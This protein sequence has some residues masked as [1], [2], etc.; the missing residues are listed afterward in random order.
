MDSGDDRG[1][2]PLREV[3]PVVP[4][5]AVPPPDPPERRVALVQLRGS[6]VVLA[7]N[8]PPL[9]ALAAHLARR[10]AIEADPP[11]AGAVT[12]EVD[13]DGARVVVE[14][15]PRF[16][17]TLVPAAWKREAEEPIVRLRRI[18]GTFADP[19]VIEAWVRRA[20]DGC[21]NRPESEEALRRSLAAIITAAA[22]CPAVCFTAASA[23]EAMRRWKWWPSAAEVFAFC[24]E[25][26]KPYRNQLRGLEAVAAAPV[27]TGPGRE[28]P[29][30]PDPR[31]SRT[32]EEVEAVRAKAAAVLAE[33]RAREAEE[34]ER[35]PAAAATRPVSVEHRIAHLEIAIREA[36]GPG[37]KPALDWRLE[38]LR[39]AVGLDA[40]ETR[41][42]VVS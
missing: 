24:E 31:A 6:E 3:L 5:R 26:A 9:P 39:R 4:L 28:R 10:V 19:R 13:L 34:R 36:G 15:P 7:A 12:T 42:E 14:R 37:R 32:P 20:A 8:P 40:V 29:P 27:G 1:P 35:R 41:G 16:A 33:V 22:D 30:E 21:A 17:P 23:V 11:A 25:V 38:T 2:V 18:L